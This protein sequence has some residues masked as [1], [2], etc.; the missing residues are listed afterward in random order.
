[1]AAYNI[2]QCAVD[3]EAALEKLATELAHAGVDPQSVAVVSKMADVTR[4][5]VKTLGNGAEAQEDPR[6]EAAETPQQEAAETEPPPGGHTIHS[7]TAALHA[8]L[9]AQHAG[10]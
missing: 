2:H 6:E 3:A 7:A 10:R 9:L 1:M 4:Q 8:H 5:L